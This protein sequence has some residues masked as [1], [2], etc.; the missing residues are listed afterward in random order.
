MRI[1]YCA[2][3]FVLR[4]HHLKSSQANRTVSLTVTLVGPVVSDI[5]LRTVADTQTLQ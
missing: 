4:T 5:L 2:V 3:Q 1:L